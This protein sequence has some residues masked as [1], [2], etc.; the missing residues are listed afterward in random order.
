MLATLFDEIPRFFTYH[1]VIFLVKAAATTLA[2]SAGGCIMGALMGFSLAIVRITRGQLLLPARILSISYVEFF[3]RIPFLVTLLFMFFVYSALGLDVSVFVVALTTV[4]LI[5]ASYSAESVRAGIESVHITQWD[6]TEAMNFTLVQ[7]LRLVIL[8]QA[9]KVILP[10]MFYFFIG[11]IKDTAL[12]SQIGVVELM[13]SG[14]VLNNKGFSAALVFGTVLAL[15]FII[16]Y[17][18]ARLGAWTEKKVGVS[19]DRKR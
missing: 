13:Y 14:K 19:K 9:W 12:A 10:P 8:P 2:L 17:P 15:Y 3:R 1:H 6:T 4:C 5:A 18:L 7:K 11:F 16:S